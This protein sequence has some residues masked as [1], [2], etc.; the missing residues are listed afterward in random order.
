[1]LLVSAIVCA[2]AV[3]CFERGTEII[4]R[5]P[6]RPP[7][8]GAD[9]GLDLPRGTLS[10]YSIQDDT[11]RDH[12]AVDDEVTTRGI[13]TAIDTLPR[14]DNV[15]SFGHFWIQDPAG[16]PFSGLYIFNPGGD[17]IDHTSLVLGQLVEVTGE[18]TEFNG[19][20]EIRL[21]RATVIDETPVP[22]APQ[23]V[24]PAEVA[25]GGARA[26]EFESVLV[27][28]ENVTVLS[29]EVGFGQ[30]QV[31]GGLLID[32][33]LT[34]YGLPDNDA[35][36]ERITGILAFSF[37]EVQLN[38]RS[39]DDLPSGLGGGEVSIEEIQNPDSPN[40]PSPNSPVIVTGVI[41]AVDGRIFEDDENTVGSFWIQAEGGGPYS[42]IQVFNPGGE[43]FD[44]TQLMIG[45]TVEVRGQYVEFF[46]LSEISLQSLTVLDVPLSIP[47]P[48]PVDAADVA[49]G[50][51]DAAAFEGGVGR[52]QAGQVTS[53]TLGFGAF[54]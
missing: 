49:P 45:Q 19:L 36:L 8:G 32:D 22:L 51:G 26:E 47:A 37:D 53:D 39:S 38:P 4:T 31:T 34:Q 44:H 42:G 30:F 13:V 11:A 23:V 2:V 35:V 21:D 54:E 18:Y 10:I 29:N 25:T 20:S 27:S 7:A 28:V 12:P 5:G 9:S 48:T 15:N 24:D 40:H 52:V 3:S 43:A 1:L 33:E 17:A 14:G 46:D 41:S 6:A 50:G 16:G